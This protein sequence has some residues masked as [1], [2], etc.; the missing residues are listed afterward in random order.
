MT[1]LT[2]HLFQKKH[3]AKSSA[4]ESFQTVLVQIE[5]NMDTYEHGSQTV[6][7]VTEAH[8]Y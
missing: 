4:E 5:L 7:G 6:R 8:N 2:Y 1:N 3:S